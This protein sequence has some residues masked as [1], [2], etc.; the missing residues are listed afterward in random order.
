MIVS[1][2][3]HLFHSPFHSS[4]TFRHFITELPYLD[5]PPPL[6]TATGLMQSTWTLELYTSLDIVVHFLLVHLILFPCLLTIFFILLYHRRPV[7]SSGPMAS[8]IRLNTCHLEFLIHLRTLFHF[9]SPFVLHHSSWSLSKSQAFPD[10][11]AM[12]IPWS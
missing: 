8:F 12:Y 10:Y 2:L 5:Q 4:S 6:K 1:R 7:R 11:K 3:F 9:I